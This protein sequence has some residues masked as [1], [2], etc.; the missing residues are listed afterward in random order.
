LRLEIALTPP[1]VTLHSASTKQYI[2]NALIGACALSPNSKEEKLHL[3]WHD[4]CIFTGSIVAGSQGEQVHGKYISPPTIELPKKLK[5]LIDIPRTLCLTKFPS[6]CHA[7]HQ[8][9]AQGL[10]NARD[11]VKSNDI[12]EALKTLKHGEIHDE[13]SLDDT[14]LYHRIM[15]GQPVGCGAQ[16]EIDRGD[17]TDTTAYSINYPPKPTGPYAKAFK[18]SWN[19]PIPEVL[20]VEQDLSISTEAAKTNVFKFQ[21]NSS[22][23]SCDGPS[24]LTG[25]RNNQFFTWKGEY[26]NNQFCSKGSLFIGDNPISVFTMNN[27]N[28]C[29]L[30]MQTLT[31]ICGWFTGNLLGHY[32]LKSEVWSKPNEWPPEQ[33]E[34]FISEFQS[35]PHVFSGYKASN[36]HV[37]GLW[38]DQRILVQEDQKEKYYTMYAGS[39]ITETNT[40]LI[41]VP[42]PTIGKRILAGMP[43]GPNL[44]LL[45]HG[46]VN[47]SFTNIENF[48]L[49]HSAGWLFFRGKGIPYTQID[50]A[51][52][53]LFNAPNYNRHYYSQDYFEEPGKS[54]AIDMVFSAA[55]GGP[56]FIL[57]RP[58][59]FIE[60]PNHQSIYCDANGLTQK[61]LRMN[62]EVRMGDITFPSGIRYSGEIRERNHVLYPQGRFKLMFKDLKYQGVAAPNPEEVIKNLKGTDPDSQEYLDSLKQLFGI[63]ELTLSGLI[64]LISDGRSYDEDILPHLNVRTLT[65]STGDTEPTEFSFK[66]S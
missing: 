21:W 23:K 66:P 24:E 11:L 17:N 9:T 59:N 38:T 3:I 46:Q 58:E 43:L 7:F 61:V 27:E 5:G 37:F 31:M 41:D 12:E 50:Q 25:I 45:P 55:D 44:I 18:N 51:S 2:T 10:F 15:N 36:G 14:K 33:F 60:E 47:K 35:G 30:H 29:P 40:A 48:D 42:L 54:K 6:F 52:S 32:P 22:T 26:K 20:V 34:G 63:E 1:R 64:S 19:L 53:I 57:V 62:N 16:I 56:D 13:S 8:I 65:A 28:D 49:L 39:F 4:G